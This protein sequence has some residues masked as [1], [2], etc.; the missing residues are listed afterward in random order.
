MPFVLQR[1]IGNGPNFEQ[2]LRPN[3]VPKWQAWGLLLRQLCPAAVH[4]SEGVL[5]NIT[6]DSVLYVSNR[7]AVQPGR[8]GKQPRWCW[9]CPRSPPV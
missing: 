4:D 7:P 5:E 9:R 6:P 2:S 3:L 1:L 8:V